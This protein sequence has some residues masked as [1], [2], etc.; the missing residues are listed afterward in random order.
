[1]K[2]KRLL[3]IGCSYTSLYWTH[4]HGFPVW[5]QLLAEKLDMDCI[6]LGAN[7]AGNTHISGQLFDSIVEEKFDFI[8]IM[9]S[10]FQRMD[11]QELGLFDLQEIDTYIPAGVWRKIVW[12][13]LHPHRLTNYETY[14]LD[15]AAKNKLLKYNSIASSTLAAF[16]L[17][18][19]TQN[20]LKDIPYFMIQGCFPVGKPTLGPLFEHNEPY[21]YFNII[22][23][24]CIRFM[25][26]SPY[27]DL[28]ESKKFIGWPIM[29]QLGGFA[30]DHHL[31]K[32]DPE[33]EKYRM[34][35]SKDS[36][37]NAVGHELIS[38]LI[39]DNYKKVYS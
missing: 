36:H 9:W 29:P 2:R 20:I 8:V 38:E 32:L 37:P 31:D 19:I 4:K 5:P 23:K 33:R 7:G 6:N 24:E 27:I 14:K 16:R 12:Q 15:P 39:Y 18:W 30:V 10:E 3:A 35:G 22:M 17:F 34:E 25:L 13:H 1:M 11:F 21:D 28:I 26:K